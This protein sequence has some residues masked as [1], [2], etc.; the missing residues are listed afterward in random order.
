MSK[1]SYAAP[2]LLSHGKLEDLT[3]ANTPASLSTD[4]AFPAGTRPGDFTFT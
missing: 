3:Y 4:A 1:K 2:R